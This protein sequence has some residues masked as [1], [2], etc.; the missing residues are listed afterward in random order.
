[1]LK[2]SLGE[3]I[4]YYELLDGSLNRQSL[5]DNEQ[6][7]QE[8]FALFWQQVAKKFK[9]NPYVLGELNSLMEHIK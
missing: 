4:R 7:V 1:M 2:G 6:N 3:W 8:Y 5:Y 9:Q